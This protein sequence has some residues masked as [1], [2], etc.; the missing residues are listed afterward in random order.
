MGR[1]RRER[2]EVGKGWRSVDRGGTIPEFP[3]FGVMKKIFV[4]LQ[5]QL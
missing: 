3:V 2:A 1:W 5:M 4:Y